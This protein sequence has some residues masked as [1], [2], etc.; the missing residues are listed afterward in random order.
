MST[1]RAVLDASP[2]LAWIFG[3]EGH[4]VVDRVIPYGAVTSVNL[5]EVV[6]HSLN[7]GYARSPKELVG[8]LEALGLQV[9]TDFSTIDA[10][11]A[12]EL[13]QLSYQEKDRHRGRT[14][15]FADAV[16]LAVAERLR[17]PAVTG[18]RLWRDLGHLLTIEAKLFR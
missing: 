6:R 5:A 3:E 7:R 1:P 2:L 11:R 12:G 10:V 15:A 4:D 18:D 17:L 16:C 14:L 13:V 8:D 9:V